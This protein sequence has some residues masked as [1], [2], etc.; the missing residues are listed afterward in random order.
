V[1][2]SIITIVAVA[3]TLVGL[4][5]GNPDSAGGSEWAFAGADATQVG[6]DDAG[7]RERQVL[8]RS[9]GT[10]A[11]GVV[12]DDDTEVKVT[13]GKLQRPTEDQWKPVSGLGQIQGL[14]LV[15][16]YN[17]TKN[18]KTLSQRGP[19]VG[20]VEGMV[21]ERD[22]RIELRD[23]A[24]QKCRTAQGL[25][26][27]V[28]PRTSDGCFYIDGEVVAGR[29]SV[30][31]GRDD[32]TQKS[33]ALTVSFGAETSG[34]AKYECHL[35][36][37]DERKAVTFGV[38]YFRIEVGSYPRVVLGEGSVQSTCTATNGKVTSSELSV[39]NVT[40]WVSGVDRP[41]IRLN[42][43][44]LRLQVS[45]TAGVENDEDGSRALSFWTSLRSKDASK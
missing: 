32:S 27:R 24:F 10:Q 6:S 4:G 12:L 44:A 17:E 22:R 18:R 26:F 30:E 43:V 38:E 13:D 37:E 41:G 42:N 23:P 11:E 5:C 21:R 45:G 8:F 16:I 34:Q 35:V 31:D 3:F 33:P 28:A 2:K 15:Q 1:R 7:P 25:D 19:E 20:V 39:E 14:E 29:V 40:G 9:D 36:F